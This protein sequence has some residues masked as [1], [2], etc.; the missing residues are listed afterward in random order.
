MRPRAL[1]VSVGID[2]PSKCNEVFWRVH[3]TL[4]TGRKK[5]GAESFFNH[6]SRADS[7]SYR[8]APLREKKR[9]AEFR[10]LVK[11]VPPLQLD[12]SPK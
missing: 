10:S 5:K 9:E 12:Y 4:D 3:A 11:T 6:S 7:I 2:L 1:R 8:A